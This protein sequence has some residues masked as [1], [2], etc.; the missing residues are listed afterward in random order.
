M[1]GARRAV[2]VLLLVPACFHPSYDRPRC[3]PDGECPVG[4]TCIAQICEGMGGSA[5]DAAISDASPSICWA[6][7]DFIYG[8]QV[9]ACPTTLVGSIDVIT[10][11]SIDTDAGTSNPP[12][13]TCAPLGTGSS[14]VC[15]LA[16]NKITIEAGKTL[17]AHGTK[18]LALL[19]HS[20]DIEGTIDVAS[21]IGGQRGPASNLT[22]CNPRV[23]ATKSGG[24]AGGALD[25]VAGKGGDEGGTAGTG[26]AAGT[27]IA[28]VTLRGGCDGGRGGDGSGNGG[29]AGLGGAGGGAVWIA[30]DTGPFTIGASV[31]TRA[32]RGESSRIAIGEDRGA[33]WV[34]G[35]QPRGT[36]DARS[37]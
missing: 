4:L 23:A 2:W 10:N 16:A 5:I 15:A 13:L 17:A 27:S 35:C 28:I 14:N 18:P 21:H 29:P 25:S 11:V 30:V 19:G 8:F 31:A 34:A 32:F 26:G 22:G 20:I 9:K 1:T 7:D 37:Q 33:I 36:S 6:I 12:G 3:G 24:G